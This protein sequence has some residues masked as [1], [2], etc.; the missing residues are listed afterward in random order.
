LK[1]IGVYALVNGL[2]G[3]AY[4]RY[5]MGLEEINY[6]DFLEMALGD[7]FGA[8]IFLYIVY[9]FREPIKKISK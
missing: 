8:I 2:A 4:F 1:L 7:F 6:Y 3:C 9:L 5:N